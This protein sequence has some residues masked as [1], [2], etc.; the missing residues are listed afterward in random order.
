MRS[1][2]IIKAF[3]EASPAVQ[4]L[5]ELLPSGKVYDAGAGQGRNALWLA[6]HGYDVTAVEVS[7]E[8]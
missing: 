3:G 8:G 5:P 6:E 2:R 4:R 7:P 1:I